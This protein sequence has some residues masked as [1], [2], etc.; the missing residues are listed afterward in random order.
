M[1]YRRETRKKKLGVER[2]HIGSVIAKQVS[3]GLLQKTPIINHKNEPFSQEIQLL[4]PGLNPVSLQESESGFQ[5]LTELR[6][7]ETHHF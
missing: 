4:L 5:F 1:D 6:P 2:R 3:L 7:P